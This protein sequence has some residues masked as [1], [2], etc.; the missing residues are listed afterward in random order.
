MRLGSALVL[1]SVSVPLVVLAACKGDE[2]TPTVIAPDAAPVVEE[3]EDS[4]GP[5]LVKGCPGEVPATYRWQPPVEPDPTA[6]SEAELDGL[7]D[8][9]ARNEVETSADVA[10][11]LEGT[12]EACAIGAVDDERWRAVIPG[13]EGSYVGNTGG[14]VVLLGGSETCGRATDHLSVC[15]VTGCAGCTSRAKQD[16]C[17]DKLTAADGACAELLKTVRKECTAP[18]LKNAFDTNGPCQSLALTV[19]LF[20]GPPEKD[21]G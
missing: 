12:C 10:R 3:E 9:I 2:A 19:R 17:A 4:G 6:C 5:A 13:R 8:A 11:K 7:A 20:C 15:L 18:S 1:L 16:E 21:G 14:C